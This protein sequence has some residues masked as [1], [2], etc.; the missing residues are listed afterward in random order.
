MREVAIIG[1]GQTPVAEQWDKS[2]R[3]IA[4]EAIFAAL[5]LAKIFIW[6]VQSPPARFLST[7]VCF[8]AVCR[9]FCRVFAL[10]RMLRR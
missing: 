3:E 5:T 10:S 1:I 4:G 6:G 8:P 7:G 2:L 9:C